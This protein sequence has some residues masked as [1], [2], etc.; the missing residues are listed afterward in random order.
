M[1]CSEA[2]LV[3]RPPEERAQED[4]FD[5]LCRDLG[6]EPLGD[7]N[8]LLRVPQHEHDGE[9]IDQRDRVQMGAAALSNLVAAG[10]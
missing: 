3:L 7:G 6:A 4:T 8:W 1:Q 9:L 2:G 5:G 10:F